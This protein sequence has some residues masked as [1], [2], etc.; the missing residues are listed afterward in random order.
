[1]G[2]AS[3]AGH[4]EVDWDALVEATLSLAGGFG[5]C[6][7]VQCRGWKHLWRAES[8]V[9]DVHWRAVELE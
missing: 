9:H 2:V 3:L 8:Q 7:W 4:L 6:G 1:V 5:G